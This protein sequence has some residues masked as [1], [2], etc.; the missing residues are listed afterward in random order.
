MFTGIVEEVGKIKKIERNTV[1]A[2]LSIEADKVLQEVKEGDSIAVNGICL[3][4]TS[5]TKNSFT[6]DVMHETM[7][8]TTLGKLKENSPVN[9]ERALSVMGRFGGH[10][11]SGHIDGRGKIVGIEKDDNA[12]L[13]TIETTE[14]ILRYIVEKGSI[15]INGISLT[16]ARVDRKNFTVSVIPHTLRVTSLGS[17]QKGDEVNLENDI[18][19]KYIEKLLGLSCPEKKE[20]TLTMDFLIK[21]GF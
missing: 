15:A 7:N 5:F 16:V 4:V 11:V 1:S 9:L 10:M 3:T 2:K 13:F 14:K 20:S 18:V 17:F 8:R 6:A 21:N 19:G 12:V